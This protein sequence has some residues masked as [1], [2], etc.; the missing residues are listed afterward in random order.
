MIQLLSPVHTEALIEISN[1]CFRISRES[2]LNVS[3][4]SVAVWTTLYWQSWLFKLNKHKR[5]N[6]KSKLLHGK[7]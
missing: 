7:T 5:E 3:Y 4:A 6:A 1:F 2:V